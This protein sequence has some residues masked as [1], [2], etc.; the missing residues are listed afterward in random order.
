MS[1][2][3][4]KKKTILLR[5]NELYKCTK[6]RFRPKERKK[7]IEYQGIKRK[8]EKQER[9][10]ERY[11]RKRRN[12]INRAEQTKKARVVQRKAEG[13]EREAKA[14]QPLERM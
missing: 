5:E 1:S 2:V 7:D 4:E 9:K 10:Q 14:M 11:R 3:G 6:A 13:Q 8:Q 12:R